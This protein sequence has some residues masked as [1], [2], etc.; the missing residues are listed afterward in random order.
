MCYHIQVFFLQTYQMYHYLFEKQNSPC[1]FVDIECIFQ[2][3]SC[4]MF[5][6]LMDSSYKK[7]MSDFKC[8]CCYLLFGNIDV[9]FSFEKFR[10]QW[11][12]AH[13][14]SIGSDNSCPSNNLFPL[15]PYWSLKSTWKY[16]WDCRQSIRLMSQI[17]A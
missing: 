14:P 7:I 1:Y 17:Y 11:D 16:T 6:F 3:I 8:C 2:L 13:S 9:D 12:W 4:K 5:I 10:H 15:Y